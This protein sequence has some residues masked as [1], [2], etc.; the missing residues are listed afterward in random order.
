M[1]KKEEKLENIE[2]INLMEFLKNIPC[3]YMVMDSVDI[4]G[5]GYKTTIFIKTQTKLIKRLGYSPTIEIRAGILNI[6][7]IPVLNIQLRIN[8]SD[9]LHFEG[10]LNYMTEN[11][12]PAFKDFSTI[13]NIN[14]VFVNERMEIVTIVK[15]KNDIKEDF[16]RFSEI[17]SQ[18]KTWSM[19]DFDE[20]KAKLM[21][22]YSVIEL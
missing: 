6:D 19:S 18:S 3:G 22:R 5:T 7:S 9:R 10:F 2:S 1:I 21:N 15:V 17:A 14:L 11:E 8:M 20:A 4:N 13:D 12:L 16:K